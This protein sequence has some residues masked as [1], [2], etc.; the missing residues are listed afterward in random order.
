[1][2]CSRPSRREFLRSSSVAIAATS[3]LGDHG[4][5]AQAV[6]SE[7]QLSPRTNRQAV[8][9]SRREAGEAARA[10]LLQGGNAVDAAVAALAV[11][12]VIDPGKVSFGGYGGSMVLYHAKSRGMRAIDFTTRAPRKF[13]A[14]SFNV[15]SATHGYLAVGVPAIFAGIDLALR[16]FGTLPFKT[17]A[18]PAIALAENG[19]TVTPYLGLS[20][21][22]IKNVD[23]T[24]RRALFPNGMPAQGS[25]WKQPDLANLLRRLAENGLESFYQGDI[26]AVIAKQV[27]QG[28][29]VLSVDDFRDFRGTTVEP[30]HINYRGHDLY[31]PPLPS[32][33]LTTLCILKTLEQFDLAKLTATDPDYIEKFVGSANLCWKEREKYFGDPAVVGVPSAELLS[34]DKANERAEIVRRSNPS[35]PL[36]D[37]GAAHTVNVVVVDKDQNVVSLTATNGDEFGA[38]VAIEGLGLVLGHGMSRFAL[39]PPHPNSP[40]P[41]KRPQHNMSP[42]VILK[43]GQPYAAIGMPGGLRIVT[44]TGQVAVNLIDFGLPPQQAV[45]A[46]R[47]HTDSQNKIQVTADMPPSLM[48]GLR[49]RGHTVEILEPLG[50]DANAAVINPKTSAVTAAASKSSTG[51]YVF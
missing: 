31:T 50:G 49:K 41:G 11:L 24:T 17:L 37:N 18:A 26:P 2:N 6:G 51:V 8:A 39:K 4:V 40:A 14:A 42:M 13:D 44:V 27:Q 46:P 34:E 7:R 28:G 29:G 25:S 36:Q 20:F 10:I 45:T 21:D 3:A 12:C 32:G 22:R 9:C 19:I 47:F 38:Q 48:D 33:G 15:K 35:A 43:D 5:G 30:L 23:P 1:M 16:E